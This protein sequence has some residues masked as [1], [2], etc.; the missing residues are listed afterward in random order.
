MHTHEYIFR[1]V[2]QPTDDAL[3]LFLNLLEV[4]VFKLA[5]GSLLQIGLDKSSWNAGVMFFHSSH[6]AFFLL[7]DVYALTDQF[8][9][10]S[11]SHASEQYAFSI[12]FQNSTALRSCEGVIYH[13]WYRVKKRIA[14]IFLPHFFND[15]WFA[16]PLGGQTGVCSKGNG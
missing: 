1:D 9:P 5:D 15:K 11:R 16:L 12:V 13:Y 6:A 10:S 7:K 8:Y 3:Q 14:D 2:R 4:T